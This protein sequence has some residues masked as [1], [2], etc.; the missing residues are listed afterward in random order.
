MGEVYKGFVENRLLQQVTKNIN[1]NTNMPENMTICQTTEYTPQYASRKGEYIINNA[2]LAA[3]A[4]AIWEGFISARVG[5][6]RL[7]SCIA[8]IHPD[9]EREVMSQQDELPA[10]DTRGTDEGPMIISSSDLRRSLGGYG[11]LFLSEYVQPDMPTQIQRCEYGRITRS[12]KDL[13][14][15]IEER[16]HLNI[17][18]A[19]MYSVGDRFGRRVL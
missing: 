9:L 3:V 6:E 11:A 1:N 14:M 17:D 10:D 12:G 4:N 5:D 8:Q 2:D 15:R 16:G 7:F 19:F 18:P 13:V